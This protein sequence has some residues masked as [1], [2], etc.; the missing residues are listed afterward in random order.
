MITEVWSVYPST[1]PPVAI[2]QDP[3]SVAFQRR[4]ISQSWTRV[5]PLWQ[6]ASFWYYRFRISAGSVPPRHC[7][8]VVPYDAVWLPAVQLSKSASWLLQKPFV[9][10]QISFQ[11]PSSR[12]CQQISFQPSPQTPST[13]FPHL[14]SHPH[15]PKTIF[16]HCP[17]TVWTTWPSCHC[18]SVYSAHAFPYQH[19]W[20]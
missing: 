2:P 17:N 15:P 8:T 16:P 10:P 19:T 9:S 18:L 1:S 6:W 3:R 5:R 12:P 20:H 14:P 7:L 4:N 13:L 11:Q